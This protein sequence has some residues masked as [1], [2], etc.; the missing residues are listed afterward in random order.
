VLPDAPADAPPAAAAA[1]LTFQTPDDFPPAAAAAR[2][3]FGSRRGPADFSWKAG[4]SA[5]ARGSDCR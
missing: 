1:R 2:L 3:T 4:G 5:A